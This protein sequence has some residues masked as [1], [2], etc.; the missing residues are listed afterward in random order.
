MEDHL[1]SSKEVQYFTQLKHSK[2]QLKYL[3]KRLQELSDFTGIYFQMLSE[4]FQGKVENGKN[5]NC[6]IDNKLF[7]K[8]R[9]RVE[10]ICNCIQSTS[11]SF[12]M[13]QN[14]NRIGEI[15][16]SYLSVY[17][18]NDSER[19]K[20]IKDEDL[21]FSEITNTYKQF[22]QFLFVYSIPFGFFN[23]INH[24][25][26]ND[27]YNNKQYLQ[28][29]AIEQFRDFYWSKGKNNNQPQQTK[30]HWRVFEKFMFKYLRTMRI[31]INKEELQIY[32]KLI[33]D[34][35]FQSY[36]Y[37]PLLQKNEQGQVEAVVDK[38]HSQKGYEENFEKPFM[39]LFKNYYNRKLMDILQ[40]S[41]Q[42]FVDNIELIFIEEEQWGNQF[43]PR[44]KDKM[45]KHI[46]QVILI[47]NV[48]VIV[49]EVI[50]PAIEHRQ[51]NTI[52]VLLK[53]FKRSDEARKASFKKIA[54]NFADYVE[55]NLNMIE[56]STQQF[57]QEEEER[58]AKQ[59][60]NTQKKKKVDS[61]TKAQHFLKSLID[62]K[63]TDIMQSYKKNDDGQIER[64]IIQKFQLY[65][66]D[67]K[68]SFFPD[69]LA[70]YIDDFSLNT[71]M[72]EI[73]EIE[74]KKNDFADVIN[75]IED[76]VIFLEQY[77]QYLSERLLNN[78]N[79][80]NEQYEKEMITL[81]KN[82]CGS[83]N[84]VKIENLFKDQ[85][86][87][88]QIQ[89]KIQE[90]HKI[91]V[92]LKTTYVSQ[93]DWNYQVSR[94][95]QPINQDEFSK[96]IQQLIKIQKEEYEK[97][98]KQKKASLLYSE[99]TAQLKFPG[100][101]GKNF[102]LEVTTVQLI[103]I[104]KLQEIRKQ[105]PEQEEIA[106]KKLKSALGISTKL[107][108][109][110]LYALA[111]YEIIV[112]KLDK[113]AKFEDDDTIKINRNFNNKS[114]KVNCKPKGIQFKLE[115]DEEKLAQRVEQQKKANQQKTY[116]MEATIV[117]IMKAK[118]EM[119]LQDLI[120]EVVEQVILFVAERNQIKK[121]IESLIER[122]FM[123]RGEKDMSLIIYCP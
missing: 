67:E 47:Q 19:L 7:S 3:Q 9:A 11:C 112:R 100:V 85:E 32:I 30:I 87:S 51:C 72:Y 76:K 92:E 78:L 113:K 109:Q 45:L 8:I 114:L 10:I 62:F 22:L 73:Q 48:D 111:Q 69:Q 110:N 16:F 120:I 18:Q 21:I 96:D 94:S 98:H 75:W 57:V 37:A 35:G 90:N 12:E 55:K 43:Y 64:L 68:R 117:R 46:E 38:Q 118:R 25:S 44:S 6:K 84:I 40:L 61:R 50:K 122:D 54:Q 93:I 89:K 104:M 115:Q 31:P 106:Y 108:N 27:I 5:K 36:E 26:N 80:M 79:K 2:D 20:N 41:R 58:M 103:I 23:L 52:N 102:T 74:N 49:S 88:K 28:S 39:D 59:A 70:M 60:G 63:N 42:E 13:Q 14:I 34:T 123:K 66:R 33:E 95:L 83:Q 119:K 71:K 99:G 107:F 101:S 1:V 97:V 116:I 77:K 81:L 29:K 82:I 91:D 24:S 15:Y 53:L 17:L 105:N 56:Y 65:F 4:H 86:I 121:C